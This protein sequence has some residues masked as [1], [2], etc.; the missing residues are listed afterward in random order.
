[1]RDLTSYIEPCDHHVSGFGDAMT[2]PVEVIRLP[3]KLISTYDENIQLTRQ[4]NFTII[5]RLSTYNGFLDRPFV[6]EFKAA[7]STY[8]YCVKFP[9]KLGVETM[10]GD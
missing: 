8:Y 10:K 9:S 2:T 7:E 6:Q 5:D 1:M 4:A 3:I